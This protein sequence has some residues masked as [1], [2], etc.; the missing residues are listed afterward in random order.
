MIEYSK[1]EETIETIRCAE[2]NC[3]NIKKVGLPFV[4]IVKMQLA[5]ALKLLGAD[6]D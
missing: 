3:D 5:E 2:I 1:I 4:E 6:H